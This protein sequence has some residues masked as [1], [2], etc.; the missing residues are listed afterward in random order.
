MGVLHCSRSACDNIMCD[1]HIPSVGYICSECQEEFLYFLRTHSL[2]FVES[3]EIVDALRDFLETPKDMYT[4]AT[5][6]FVKEFF[7][8]HAK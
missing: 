4:N 6:E 2:F 1:T 5:E 8:E 3:E 7:T